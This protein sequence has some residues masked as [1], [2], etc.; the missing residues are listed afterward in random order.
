[1]ICL[2]DILSDKHEHH[3]QRT[4][5]RSSQRTKHSEMPNFRGGFSVREC[6]DRTDLQVLVLGCDQFPDWQSELELRQGQS[7][8][9]VVSSG[10]TRTDRRLA[11]WSPNTF[12]PLSAAA[13]SLRR[14]QGDT[15]RPTASGFGNFEVG[16]TSGDT[17]DGQTVG[18]FGEFSTQQTPA[19]IAIFFPAL[20]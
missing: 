20:R 15:F 16:A 7:P 6:N 8:S 1:M 12:N 3:V 4:P 14:L 13:A 5:V 11:D 2:R 9:H 19:V 17:S 10:L 18:F